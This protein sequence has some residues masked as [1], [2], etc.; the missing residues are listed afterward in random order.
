MSVGQQIITNH[1]RKILHGRNVAADDLIGISNKLYALSH[2]RCLTD[3][4]RLGVED[5]NTIIEKVIKRLKPVT[6][7][8]RAK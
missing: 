6:G 5:A 4:E 2:D 3:L 1:N 7:L 8:L